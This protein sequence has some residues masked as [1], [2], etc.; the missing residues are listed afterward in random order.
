MAEPHQRRSEGQ[1]EDQLVKERRLEGRI[2]ARTPAGR[3]DG[4]IAS[5]H[6]SKVGRP[7]SSWSSRCR[8]GRP[9]G[10]QQRWGA[11]REPRASAWARRTRHIPAAR[12]GRDPA[13]DAQPSGPHRERP[14][15]HVRD[16]GRGGE[17][18][19]DAPA[20]I[21]AGTAHTVTSPTSP[22]P[23]AA[24]QRRRVIQIASAMPTTYISP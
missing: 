24:R 16:I 22:G 10:H 2:L 5:A 21:P 18:E 3:C 20:V 4:E 7:N 17:V 9:P 6:G 14:V 8:S 1:V 15:P 12:P 23:L 19:V 11:R 13:P